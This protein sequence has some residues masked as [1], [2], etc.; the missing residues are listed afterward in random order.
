MVVPEEVPVVPDVAVVV[1]EEGTVVVAEEV[2]PEVVVD[3]PEA[4]AGLLPPATVPFGVAGV[5]I[6]GSCSP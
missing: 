3:D 4:P 1:P 2:P 5:T 6:L